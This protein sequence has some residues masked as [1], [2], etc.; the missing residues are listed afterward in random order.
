MQPLLKG[1]NQSYWIWRKLRL[2]RVQRS[3]LA[4]LA[5]P[6]QAAPLDTVSVSAAAQLSH[7]SQPPAPRTTGKGSSGWRG[8][9][10]NE[11]PQVRPGLVPLQ[12]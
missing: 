2:W 11:S 8:V 4:A 5:D 12:L 6:S 9:G 10:G 3:A 1:C 7:G